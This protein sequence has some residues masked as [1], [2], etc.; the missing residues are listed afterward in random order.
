MEIT[1]QAM[2]PVGNGCICC[3]M[4]DDMVKAVKEFAY[5]KRLDHLLIELNCISKSLPVASI[6]EFREENGN[7]LSYILTLDLMITQY[8]VN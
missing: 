4:R 1:I 5:Q 8:Y 7:S 3:T 6:I 2:Q